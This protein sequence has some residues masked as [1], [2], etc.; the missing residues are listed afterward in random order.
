MPD[1]RTSRIEPTKVYERDDLSALA[2]E[3]S[4]DLELPED[5]DRDE[6]VGELAGSVMS[7]FVRGQKP[8]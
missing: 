8:G 2:V 4:A 3:L 1:S 6:I 7:A 5:I